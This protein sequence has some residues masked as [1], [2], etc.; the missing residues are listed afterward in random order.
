MDRRLRRILRCQLVAALF[1]IVFLIDVRMG[2]RNAVHEQGAEIGRWDALKQL[3]EE[4]AELPEGI[5]LVADKDVM[6]R[7]GLMELFQNFCFLF[8]AVL[9][10][11]AAIVMAI[12]EREWPGKDEKEKEEP[13][14]ES[15]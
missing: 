7:P 12:Q 8:P 4:G 13:E 14:R 6:N 1:G 9:F 2:W 5:Q 3:Q 10:Q 11:G 15:G